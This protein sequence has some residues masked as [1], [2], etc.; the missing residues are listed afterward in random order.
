M[1]VYTRCSCVVVSA[2]A[3]MC[4][5]QVVPLLRRPT[6]IMCPQLT[7]HTTSYILQ[8]QLPWKW[9]HRKAT[10][11][12]KGLQCIASKPM[13]TPSLAEP[14]RDSSCMDRVV[15]V[16]GRAMESPVPDEKQREL[17]IFSAI[18]YLL[19]AVKIGF[20]L[21]LY[22]IHTWYCLCPYWQHLQFYLVNE[23]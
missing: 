19:Q 13:Y 12:S 4:K 6:H 21:Q 16:C 22:S 18:L 5:Y 10:T 2:C 3:S 7:V 15:E 23:L 17:V 9:G 1:H 11:H 14:A 20:F 8:H